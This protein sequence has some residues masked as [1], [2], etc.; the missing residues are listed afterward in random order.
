MAERSNRRVRWCGGVLVAL[1][2]G[3]AAGTPTPDATS[4]PERPRVLPHGL[5]GALA[6]DRAGM[7]DSHG[8]IAADLPSIRNR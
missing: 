8:P 7:P 2:G 5:V 4:P 1:L 6:A 3:C